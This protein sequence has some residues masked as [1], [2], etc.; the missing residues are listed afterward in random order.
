VGRR[1]EEKNRRIDVTVVVAEKGH[2]T[3]HRH[4]HDHDHD[5]DL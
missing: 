3:G 2:E 5:H 1:I 4:G